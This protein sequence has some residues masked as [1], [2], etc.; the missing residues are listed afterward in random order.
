M[1]CRGRRASVAAA[2]AASLHRDCGRAAFRSEAAGHFRWNRRPSY[3]GRG[4]GLATVFF[5]LFRV[6]FAIEAADA[7]GV[8]HCCAQRHPFLRDL[9]SAEPGCSRIT[10]LY[11]ARGTIIFACQYFAI[12]RRPW[13][14]CSSK[15][16]CPRLRR[17]SLF[18][19]RKGSLEAFA[20][21][22]LLRIVG[23]GARGCHNVPDW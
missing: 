7:S 12:S 14:P 19:K 16:R 3:H 18:G 20:L 21:Y 15:A 5:V 6:S 8:N 9:A 1:R 2:A 4:A 17:L 10:S 11:K 13:S 22:R 23:A